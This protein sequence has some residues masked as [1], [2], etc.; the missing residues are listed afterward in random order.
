MSRDSAPYV[1][2]SDTSQAAAESIAPEA[3][4][5]REF[6]F[7]HIE[8]SRGGGMTCDEVEVEAAMSHQTTSARIRELAQKGRIIDSG[9]RRPTRSG[10]M[11]IVWIETPEPLP[12]VVV[13]IPEVTVE[14]QSLLFS[15]KVID[16]TGEEGLAGL[17]RRCMDCRR[18]EL[19]KSRNKIV[20]GEGNV[21]EPLICF[22]GEGPGGT[23]D[24]TGRPFVGPAGRFLDKVISAM[25]LKRADL[26]ICNVV[27]CRPE[28]NR[29]PE[30]KELDACFEYLVG[31]LRAV[32]P[33][34]IVALGSTA[35]SAFF[36]GK[37]EITKVRGK[38][39]EWEKIP[40][41]PTFHPSYLLRSQSEP[42]FVDLKKAMWSD[43]QQVMHKLGNPAPNH[44][45]S[46]TF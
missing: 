12:A 4:Q 1:K 43:M 31:Q 13:P 23:E 46:S 14:G 36:G 35:V 27:C 28:N 24:D 32:R 30:K 6:V 26:Y 8:R 5:L 20:F 16:P 34:T 42:F 33:K 22:V 45:S 19:S 15:T 9:R 38:W 17:R 21:N 3:S 29:R 44:S 37:Q 40:L 11:A 39:M 25:K 18:C 2:G 10:R 41:M 7:S